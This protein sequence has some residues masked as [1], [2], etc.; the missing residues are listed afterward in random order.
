[1]GPLLLSVMNT[2]DFALE[3]FSGTVTYVL[4]LWIVSTF[5]VGVPS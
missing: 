5:P 3:P 1:M 2:S 4:R